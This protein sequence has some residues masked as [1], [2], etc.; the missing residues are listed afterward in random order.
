[1]VRLKEVNKMDKIVKELM[2]S[3]KNIQEY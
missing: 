2:Q 1:M 3:K